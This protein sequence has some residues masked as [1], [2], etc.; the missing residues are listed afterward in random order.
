MRNLK[1]ISIALVLFPMFLTAQKRVSKTVPLHIKV[2]AIKQL[3][4]F[5]KYNSYFETPFRVL[6]EDEIKLLKGLL[7]V[8]NEELELFNQERKDEYAKI[9]LK[10]QNSD[11]T[12]STDQQNS[13]VKLVSSNLITNLNTSKPYSELD[14]NENIATFDI[15]SKLT[16]KDASGNVLLDT[17][18][19]LPKDQ[20]FLPKFML[21]LDPNTKLLLAFTKKPEKQQQIVADFIRKFSIKLVENQLQTASDLI[22]NYFV[23]QFPQI[24]VQISGAKGGKEEDYIEINKAFETVTN[25]LSNVQVMSKTKAVSKEEVISCLESS[26]PVWEKEL[27][28]LDTNNNKAKINNDV[29]DGLKFNL[30]LAHFVLKNQEKAY[31]FIDQLADSKTK[32]GQVVMEGSFRDL[33]QK[34]RLHKV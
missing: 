5:Y 34:F 31:F 25:N 16:V 9:Y 7:K 1:F 8:T 21:Y 17:T 19:G 26:V 3:P 11:A 27:S 24:K 13:E 2:S 18:Y 33:A 20:A 29:A 23:D 14:Q 10:F 30:S 15:K 4:K 32:N 22:N 12:L 6:T 28:Q